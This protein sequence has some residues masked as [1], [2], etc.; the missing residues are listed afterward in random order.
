MVERLKDP[1]KLIPDGEKVSGSWIGGQEYP[2]G[3]LVDVDNPATGEPFARIQLGGTEVAEMAV[4]AARKAFPVWSNLSYEERG[5]Y[6]IRFARLLERFQDAIATLIATEQGKPMTEALAVELFAS[7][8]TCRYL[9]RNAAED[10]APEK[11]TYQNPLMAGKRGVVRFEPAGPVLIIT[12]WNL[13]FLIPT[14]EV[15]QALAAGNTVVLRPSPVAPF[16]ALALQRLLERAD[17]PPGVVN[18]ALVTDEAMFCLA[19]NPVIRRISF[20]GSQVGGQRIM[21]AAAEALTPV[22]LQMDGKDAAIICADCDLERTTMG[23]AWWG[24]ANAGQVSAG[25]QRVYVERSIARPFLERLARIVASLRVGDPLHPQTDIGPMTLARQRDV[26]IGHV[27]DAVARGA[28]LLV[29]GNVPTGP[30]WYYPPTLLAG[31]DHSMPVMRKDTYGPVIP[32]MVVDSIDEAVSLANDSPYGMAASVWTENPGRARIIARQLR[33][34]SVGI[35]DHGTGYGEPQATFG[36][37]GRSGIGRTHGRYGLIG[38][39]AI[40]HVSEEYHAR[41]PPW[42]FPYNHELRDYLRSAFAAVYRPGFG[43]KFER[44]RHILSLKRFRRAA[45]L[46][47]LLKRWRS[48]F[49]G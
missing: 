26:V 34:G 18:T 23:V 28:K 10:L 31:V 9:A 5:R 44:V 46:G 3:R 47:A 19:R 11:H 24:L 20:L 4:L 27:A 37:E 1:M 12:P 35:N 48:I 39:S 36:G 38:M 32:V 40:K 49:R 7:A 15:V 21:T 43:I 22:T 14:T 17:L 25:I 16:S 45:R 42:W 33:V 8:D 41:R 30:G 6:L 29:G 13:P 2:I